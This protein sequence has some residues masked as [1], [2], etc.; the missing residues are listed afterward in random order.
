VALEEGEGLVA[1]AELGPDGRQV[2]GGGE[3]RLVLARDPGR[4]VGLAELDQEGGREEGAR[5]ERV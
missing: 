1:V 2:V 4:L 5:P 3:E